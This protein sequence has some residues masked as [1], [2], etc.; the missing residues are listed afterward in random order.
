MIGAWALGVG[1]YASVGARGDGTGVGGYAPIRRRHQP[2]LSGFTA[3]RNRENRVLG[4]VLPLFELRP[5]YNCT[6][7][8]VCTSPPSIDFNSIPLK[9]SI[10]RALV[11]LTHVICHRVDRSWPLPTVT[12]V[13]D[14]YDCYRP[15][16]TVTV[17]PLQPLVIRLGAGRP[18]EPVAD[19]P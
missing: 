10:C 6:F 14:R 2:F 13:T 11:R 3:P 19:S 12:T 7:E 15:L 18:L 8:L 1:G 9:L 16:M 17:E 4:S 5:T